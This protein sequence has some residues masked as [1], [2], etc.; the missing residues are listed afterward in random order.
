M[1]LPDKFHFTAVI[2]EM[3]KQFYHGREWLKH[4]MEQ[5]VD[6]VGYRARRWKKNISDDTFVLNDQD[7]TA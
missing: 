4:R 1:D 5:R 3:Q 7:K 6:E 2:Y